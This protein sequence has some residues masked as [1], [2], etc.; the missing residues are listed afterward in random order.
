MS[1]ADD[2]AAAARAIG[3]SAL[4][5]DAG[6]SREIDTAFEAMVHQRASALMTTPEQFFTDRRV[7]IATL[8]ARHA[9]PAIYSTREIAVA[10][11]LM[12]YGISQ[13][14][15]YHQVGV[16]TGRILKGEKPAELLVIQ[17][18]EIK[19]DGYRL[20]GSPAGSSRAICSAPR[21]RL[22]RT[23]PGA[24]RPSPP[25]RNSRLQAVR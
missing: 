24:G 20:H 18:T 22:V 12:S 15:T 16:Y 5:F 17:P 13:P 25:H 23:V 8:A 14:E 11:G 9:L 4:V 6:S 10:G 2:I 7:Q 19:H 21:V 1:I 3:K